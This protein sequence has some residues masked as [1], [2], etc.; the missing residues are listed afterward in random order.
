MTTKQWLIRLLLLELLAGAFWLI[1]VA[2]DTEFATITGERIA[3]KSL[4][5]KAV[6]VTFWATDCASCLQEIP[7][8]IELYSNYHPRGLE[9]IAVATPYNP[10]NQVLDMAK[11]KQL[12]YTIAL[13]VYGENS[14]AFGDVALTPTTF[15]IAADG[16]IVLQKVGRF[17]RADMKTRLAVLL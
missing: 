16:R 6:L 11:A 8:L 10:P 1:A 15:L 3:L 4:R 14:H 17:S 12:P 13:D 5:G 2:P 9:I 7:H